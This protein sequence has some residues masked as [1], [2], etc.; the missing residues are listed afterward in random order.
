MTLFAGIFAAQAKIDYNALEVEMRMNPERYRQLTQRFIDG[1]TTLTFDELS[2][3]YYGYSMTPDYDPRDTYPQI[4]KA[5]EDKDYELAGQLSARALQTNPA[6]LELSI[7]DLDAS[8]HGAKDPAHHLRTAKMGFRCDMVANTILESGRGTNAHSPF[9]VISTAD[10][11]RILH[12]VLGVSKIIDRAKVGDI[13]AIKINLPG[14]D[15]MHILYFDNTREARF[16]K[17]HGPKVD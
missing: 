12:N 3:V 8:E 5:L 6:S 17:E 13:D 16:L 11:M 2:T 7:M 15:R 1:D 9:Y 10:M 14:S 4:A